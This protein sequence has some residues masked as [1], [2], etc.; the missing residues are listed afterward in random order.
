MSEDGGGLVAVA[1]DSGSSFVSP[2][3][4]CQMAIAR[5]LYRMNLALRASGLWLRYAALQNLIPSFPWIVPHALHPG[6]IQ[7]K[8]GIKCYH[9]ATLYV[10]SH[11][12]GDDRDQCPS[13]SAA[14]APEEDGLGPGA[15]GASQ[16]RQLHHSQQ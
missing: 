1:T 8:E 7:G 6:A 12:T 10:S 13:A 16:G 9:L 15:A 2:R 11:L 4:G 5:F 3:H 14:A